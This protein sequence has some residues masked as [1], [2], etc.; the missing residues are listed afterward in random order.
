MIDEESLTKI[1][2]IAKILAPKYTFDC[3]SVEDIEQE[4]VM[5]GIE[6]MARYDS[7][8]PLENFL[9]IH[10][11]NRLKN[12]K[13]DNYFRPN[14]EGEPEKVQ[15]NKKSILDA[16]SLTEG[17]AYFDNNIDSALDDR[18]IIEKIERELPIFYRKD[19][20]KLCAGVRISAS[21]KEDVYEAIR[22]IVNG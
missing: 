4:A 17:S 1:M 21:R 9:Y 19:Y 12:F 8:R 5:M 3:H 13:R 11:S 6:A 16:S 10:I 14:S 18:A 15:Q 20:L 7:A 22:K 2:K